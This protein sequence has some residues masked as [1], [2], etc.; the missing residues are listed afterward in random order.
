M[1]KNKTTFA[2]FAILIIAS[3]TFITA[4]CNKNA[5]PTSTATDSF[6]VTDEES[7]AAWSQMFG[8]TSLKR[9]GDFWV[10]TSNDLPNHKSVY[11]QGTQWESTNYEPYTATG[12]KSN[13]VSIASQNLTFRIPAKPTAATVHK[14]TM[15]GPI[16]IALNGVSFFNQYNGQGQKLGMEI[17]SFD[18][19]NGHCAPINHDYHYHVEPTYL[20]QT[21]GSNA[22]LGFLLDGF[23]VYGPVENG[24]T[25]TNADLDVYH[26]HIGKTKEYPNG[27][28]H[29]HIT[30]TDPYINGNGYYGTPGTVSH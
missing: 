12:F 6:V 25:I 7:N 5:A 26:G 19:Y 13:N 18:Q 14:A 16:G 15:G 4:S 17:A 21:K 11:Y 23:P 29:Y 24:V 3:T 30:S 27:I 10:V 9:D 8:I 20:T 2:V 1:K 22:L 28:Y